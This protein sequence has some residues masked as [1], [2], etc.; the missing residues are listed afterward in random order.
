MGIPG[1]QWDETKPAGSRSI[2]LG[3]DDIREMKTQIREIIAVDHEFISTQTAVT[4]G[5]HKQVTLQDSADL[6]TGATGKCFLGAQ[7]A[8][9]SAELYFTD[10]DNNDVKITDSGKLCTTSL[11]T[12][13]SISTIMNLIYPIGT[14]LTFGVSTNPATLLGVGTWTAIAGKVIVGIDGTQTEFDTLNETGGE[15]T[16]QLTVN[17]MPAHTHSVN[18]YG[19]GLQSHGDNYSQDQAGVTGS[20]GGGVAHNNLQPYIVKYVWERQS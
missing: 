2:K 15:K 6:G 10:E 19:S 8:E 4:G 3:D 18:V 16:H 14:V 17:E 12:V 9:G 13:A 20:T 11:T 5:Q 7:G 1:T